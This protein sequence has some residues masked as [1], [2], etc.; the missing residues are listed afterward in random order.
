MSRRIGE[1]L[2]PDL[3]LHVGGRILSKRVLDWLA[4]SSP[5]HYVRLASSKTP[6]DPN[7]QVTL[8]LVTDVAAACDRLS[9]TDR[10]AG[11]GEWLDSWQL[12]DAAVGDGL[13]QEI[14][15]DNETT[16]DPKIVAHV[17]KSL[18]ALPDPPVLWSAS[19]LPIRLLDMYAPGSGS[20]L[21]VLANRGASGIDGTIASAA[22]YADGSDRP[23]VLLIG[24]LAL[25]HDLT[26]LHL[27]KHSKTPITIVLLNNNGGNIFGLLP[28][29]AHAD[30]FSDYFLTPHGHTF[31]HAARQFGIAYHRCDSMKTFDHLMADSINRSESSL[32]EV[33]IAPGAGT[34]HMREIATAIR[35]VVDSMEFLP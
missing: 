23:V 25:L 28:I 27:V 20:P 10:E 5:E 6:F 8:T 31:E 34:A 1:N 22:G 19:S 24:D 33:I 11:A 18:V 7:H 12:L 4:A 9:E 15:G 2:R 35:T 16:S 30:L 3:V 17:L 32:I 14:F 13:E 21:T 26:S 29:A